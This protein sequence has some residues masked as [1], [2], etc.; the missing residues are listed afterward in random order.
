[1]SAAGLSLLLPYVAIAASSDAVRVSDVWARETVP[2]QTV[3]AAYMLLRSAEDLTLIGVASTASKTAELHQMAMKGDLM[4]MREV[5]MV[6]LSPQVEFALQPGGTH[7]ML[8]DLKRPLKA[9]GTV[10]LKL[11]FRRADGST[12]VLPVTARV[13]SM[14][15]EAMHEH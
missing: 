13:R 5:S 12:F 6:T 11:S 7:V 14:S 4:Q 8:V 3:G 15:A 1:M 9:G 10:T 2:G